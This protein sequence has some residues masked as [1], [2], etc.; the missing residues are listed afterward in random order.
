MFIEQH[1]EGPAV[2][3]IHGCPSPTSHF[4]PLVEALKGRYRVL[5]PHLPGYGRSAPLGGTYTLPRVTELLEDDLL[6]LG[7]NEAAAVGFSFGGYRALA[8]AVS[9]RVRITNVVCL[10]GYADLD[11]AAR[12]G[13]RG[14]AA[15]ARTGAD[16][17]P[18][19]APQL[20]SAAFIAANP[21]VAVEIAGWM[22]IMPREVFA[23][24]LDAA[25]V[26]D[27]LLPAIAELRIPILARVGEADVA[28]PAACSR[29]LCAAA[30]QGTLEI[31]PGVAHGLFYEDCEATVAS[32]VR[33]LQ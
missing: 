11:P 25:A 5:V 24:E 27:N 26:V 17:H 22:D 6:A 13:M 10:A 19:A 1:G 9:G 30:R 29:A 12:D 28:V 21:A 31:V 4:A 32:V 8:L 7:V 16:L 33:A 14:F 23:Q 20:L 18:L 2:L 3:L 15:F